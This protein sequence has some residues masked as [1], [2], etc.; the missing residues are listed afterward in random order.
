VAVIAG[1]VV[2][3]HRKITQ[4]TRR[5]GHRGLQRGHVPHVA[6]APPRAGVPGIREL[7]RKRLTGF[8]RNI[9][10]GNARALLRKRRHDGGAYAASS[11]GDEYRALVQAGEDGQGADGG[12]GAHGKRAG[13]V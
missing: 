6:G 12:S 3:Q 9:N 5:V 7:L 8:L 4:C 13:N 10:K 2:D 1:N 11:A